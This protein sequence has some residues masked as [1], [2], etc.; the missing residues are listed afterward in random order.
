MYNYTKAKNLRIE[1]FNRLKTYEMYMGIRKD[2]KNIKENE[3]LDKF[4]PDISKV[5]FSKV[6]SNE[7]NSINI[8]PS[9]GKP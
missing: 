7:K 2:K 3:D 5:V 8:N 6:S 4:L 9:I 1:T